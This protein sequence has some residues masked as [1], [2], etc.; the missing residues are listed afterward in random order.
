MEEW[1]NVPGY[2]GLY[3]VSNY[4]NVK[5]IRFNKEKM[6]KQGKSKTGYLCVGLFLNKSRKS[7]Y[8]HRLVW[9]AFNGDVPYGMQVN[10]MNEDK[11]DNRLE[12]LNILSSQEN[13]TW[14]TAQER[15]KQTWTKIGRIKHII[16]Y[17]LKGNQIKEWESI[18]EAQRALKITH[19]CHCLHNLQK[20]SGG[21]IWKYK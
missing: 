8:V 4:G 9:L 10:H 13:L 21:F 11:T 16:Q 12:N 17:D 18:A 1:R 3:Q 14:G 15:R 5:S 7:Q 19:I 2:E 6:L 20:T